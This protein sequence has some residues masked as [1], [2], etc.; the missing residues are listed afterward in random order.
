M[1]LRA[2]ALLTLG[3]LGLLLGTL[4]EQPLFSLVSV[5][6]VL[7]I[8][9]EWV[10]FQILMK[11]AA[12]RLQW[13]RTINGRNS[14]S[15]TLWTDRTIRVEIQAQSKRPIAFIIEVRDVVPEIL[16]VSPPTNTPDTQ[17]AIEPVLTDTSPK[18]SAL[19]VI[20]QI[21]NHPETVRLGRWFHKRIDRPG[22]TWSANHGLLE[23]G[24]RT[25]S[26]RY[27]AHMLSAGHVEFPGLRVTFH[28]ACGLFWAHRF[29]QLKQTFRILPNY[30]EAGELRPTVKRQNSLPNH[31]IHRL[32][33][34][35]L[36]SELLELRDYVA[37][38]PPKA[39]A[40]KASARRDKLLTR[41]YESEVPVRL[42]LMI[43]GSLSARM[44]GYGLRLLDQMNFVAASVAKAAISVG[45]PVS[46]L[47]IDD[48][49][50]K[51]LPWMQ[52]DRGF[53]ELLRA[54]A[55]FSQMPPLLP[56]P[57]SPYLMQCAISLCHEQYPHLL[58]RR[59]NQIPFLFRPSRRRVARLC[60]VLA[61]VF[62]LTPIQQVECM[63]DEVQ[64]AERIQQLL[65]NAGMPWMNPLMPPT[66]DSIKANTRRMQVLCQG[67]TRAMAHAHDNEVFV[68]FADL[69]SAT[70]KLTPLLRAVRLAVAKHHRVAFV[71][72][73]T[74]FTRPTPAVASPKSLTVPDLLEVAEKAR[75][76]DMANE[77]KRELLKAG[78]TVAFSGEPSAIRMVIA[79]MDVARDGRTRAVGLRT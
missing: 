53:M 62:D 67:I 57:M 68:I 29:V 38:D 41:Q 78:A 58:E 59:I 51:R 8:L 2:R 32:Q 33:R 65:S 17:S 13:S 9:L 25:R 36:G 44:G 66:Y 10:R 64:L 42:H 70:Q 1:T 23:P 55:D 34:S 30:Y 54:L 19:G 28:G 76:R 7:W 52:G 4:R 15:G 79:E 26:L 11:W 39:I 50:T 74:T 71:C 73:T 16:K 47:L 3:V 22:V 49:G 75:V 35:G 61:E 27:D 63:V 60:G 56:V 12:P 48:L 72:P 20:H 5:L 31:G 37:G 24:E 77:L 45:D 14:T 21:L 43:D 69:L 18:R 6:V 40:W 46:G